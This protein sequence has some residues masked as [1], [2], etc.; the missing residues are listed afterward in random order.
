MLAAGLTFLTRIPVW[1][2]MQ[3]ATILFDLAGL[4]LLFLLLTEWNQKEKVRNLALFL[5]AVFPP[6][7]F[8]TA[9]VRPEGFMSF[10]IL[11][12]SYLFVRYY[13]TRQIRFL[14]FCGIV[15]GLMSYFRPDFLLFCPF[16]C[17][18]FTF[19]F[20]KK[21]GLSHFL[22]YAGRPVLILAITFAMLLPWG[23]RNHRE[24]GEWIFTS[25]GA[26][27]T[28]VTGLGTYPNPWGFGPSDG[29]RHSEAVNAGF[30]DAFDVKAD[31]FF[32]KMFSEA[33]SE[34]P[35]AFLEILARRLIQPLAP[36]Y[37]WG[38][39]R[40]SG[41]SYTKF[42]FNGISLLSNWKLIL[43]NYATDIISAVLMLLGNAGMLLLFLKEKNNKALRW[44]PVLAYS[45]AVLSHV[46]THMAPYYIL[47][48]VFAQLIGL[49]F[50]IDF[51]LRK[52]P[53]SKSQAA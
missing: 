33:V 1:F 29:S 4:L 6:L 10:F 21:P 42:R 12:N 7:L 24:F 25:S 8:I 2:V 18:I 34:H 43:K 11:A 47:P 19:E 40:E 26:G 32:R 23:I 31:P 20:F 41:V 52:Y 5:Y 51:V 14:L 16:L 15:S 38:I 45:Y 36:P 9:N 44:I 49:A 53:L 22:L 13:K 48:G 35:A 17:L 30:R 27:C 46:F 50:L 37:S 28:L 3:A 39:K